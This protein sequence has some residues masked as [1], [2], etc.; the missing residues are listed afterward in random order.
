VLAGLDAGQILERVAAGLELGEPHRSQ[1]AFWCPCDLERV[2]RAVTLLGRE[3]TRD[4]AR[5]GEW[6]LVRCEFCGTQYRL[7]PDDV[8]SL[9]RDA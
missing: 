3:E 7:H 8:G 5:R 9:Y 2:R 4:M 1:P 6:A